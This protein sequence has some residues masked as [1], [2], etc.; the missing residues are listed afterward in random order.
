MAKL[1][2]EQWAEV[3]KE[4]EES[5]TPYRALAEKWDVSDVAIIKRAKKEGWKDSD[6][7]TVE[8]KVSAKVRKLKDANQKVSANQVANHEPSPINP[9]T[10][11]ALTSCAIDQLLE[12]QACFVREYAVDFNGTQAAIRAGYSERTAQEQAS[13]LLSNVMVQA[14][15]RELMADR[16]KRLEI[17]AD[18]VVRAWES[19][20]TANPNELSQ[21]RRLC[22]RHCWGEAFGY[23]YTPGEFLKAK[24]RHEE[25]RAELLSKSGGKSDI[26]DFAGLDGDW[27]QKHRD[28]NSECPECFGE[29]VGETFLQD[30]RKLSPA[31]LAMYAGVKEGREG[32][33]I[34]TSSREKARENLARS[35][36]IF[37][38]KE[39]EVNINLIAGDDLHRRY[40]E[41]MDKARERQRN[42]LIERGIIEGSAVRE[43]DLPEGDNLNS[44]FDDRMAKARER[45]AAVLAERGIAQDK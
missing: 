31:A 4:R 35:L 16:V 3:R 40:V 24:I 19:I 6:S 10:A 2:L 39:A 45:Q 20:A 41:I 8:K 44:V 22:C 43:T 9:L 5:K 36:G 21:F 23:Q 7:E 12:K 13:R 25:K 11:S 15:L 28:P 1:S 34:L 17:D 42:V 14:A 26:G 29:G 37:K 18:E 38:D 27:Y 30:T 32:I 33:E